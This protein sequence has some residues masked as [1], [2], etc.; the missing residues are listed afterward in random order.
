MS[1]KVIQWATGTVGIHAV[2]GILAHP[3]LELA[4]LWVHSESKVG[5]D[6][7]EICGIDPCGV[8]ATNDADALLALDA[9]VICYTAHSDMRPDAVVDDLCRMLEA[10]KNVVNTSFV[11]LLNPWSA[12]AGDGVGDRLQAACEAGGASFFSSGID[13]GFGNAELAIQMM[14]LSERVE[15]VRMMEIVDYSTWNNPFTLFEIMGFSKKEATESLLLSPGSITLAWGP[16]VELVGRALGVELD[17]IEEEIEVIH[18]EEDLTIDAG[19]IPAGTISGMRFQIKGMVDGV[20]A[21]VVEHVTRMQEGDAP[22]WPQGQGYRIEIGGE[23]SMVAT[24]ELDSARGDHNTA[25]C[26]AT[27]MRV[28]NAIPNLV[29]AEPGVYTALE[30]PVFTAAGIHPNG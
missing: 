2:P 14:S 29:A 24:L 12:S 9:D 11:P 16:V 19:V 6:A 27:A 13:P 23:P 21:I 22:D 8:E 28:L 5:R 26:M 18:A 25:G 10:G 15:S 3:E 1:H 20:A 7:G 17:S 4:G 30:L